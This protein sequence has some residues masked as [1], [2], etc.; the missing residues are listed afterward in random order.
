MFSLCVSAMTHAQPPL[1]LSLSDGTAHKVSNYSLLNVAV[2]NFFH[3]F[4]S[5]Q[6]SS[7]LDQNL[8]M[9]KKGKQSI[10]ASALGS[11]T[12]NCFP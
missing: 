11:Q 2:T 4:A 9:T 3:A 6:A 12:L 1:V 7:L 5:K 8:S 10:T